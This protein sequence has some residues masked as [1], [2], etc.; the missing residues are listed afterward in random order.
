MTIPNVLYIITCVRGLNHCPGFQPWHVDSAKGK[1]RFRLSVYSVFFS[2]PS[3]PLK[4]TVLS[5]INSGRN[6]GVSKVGP[7]HTS[8]RNACTYDYMYIED[9]RG[10]STMNP[11]IGLFLK[12]PQQGFGS[13][14]S[15]C[16]FQ[17]AT[18]HIAGI[19]AMSEAAL[20][21]VEDGRNVDR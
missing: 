2:T 17:E 4:I 19:P 7:Y 13:C 6:S 16:Q 10:I 14:G 15:G 5:W 1:I 21:M 8:L 12:R 9:Y 3:W 18:C 11:N 20:R